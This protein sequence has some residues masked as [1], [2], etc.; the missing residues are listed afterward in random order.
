[1]SEQLADEELLKLL[2]EASIIIRSLMRENQLSDHLVRA[3][4]KI[5]RASAVLAAL[6][7]QP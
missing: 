4:G 7:K 1:M 2:R 5:V 6:E 3:D